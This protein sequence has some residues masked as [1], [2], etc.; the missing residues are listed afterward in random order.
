[1]TSPYRV[2]STRF[3]IVDITTV[4]DINLDQLQEHFR[5]Y[6]AILDKNQPFAIVYDATKIGSVDALVR[7]AYAQFMLENEADFRR[8]CV[9]CGFVITSALVRGALTAVL[10][11]TGA[12]PMPHKVFA[13]REDAEGY[14][15]T[16]LAKV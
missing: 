2:D 4:G 11:V 7:K 10:W 8:L 15:R 6:R 9:G 14:A 16:Q 12:M 3:P 13:S 5:E 1:M